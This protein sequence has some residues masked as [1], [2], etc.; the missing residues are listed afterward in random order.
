M[1]LKGQGTAKAASKPPGRGQEEFCSESQREL[2][3]TNTLILNFWP[4]ELQNDKLLLF[5]VTL[6]WHFVTADLGN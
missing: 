2:S 3:P 4:L 5:Q 6:L 1:H